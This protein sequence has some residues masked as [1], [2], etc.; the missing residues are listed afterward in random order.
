MP[1]VKGYRNL[2]LMRCRFTSTLFCFV[3]PILLFIEVLSQT[4]WR[5]HPSV[6][7][8]RTREWLS[9]RD[10]T[11]LCQLMPAALHKPFSRVG[12]YNKN[13][14]W[15]Q[16]HIS[17]IVAVNKWRQWLFICIH[18]NISYLCGVAWGNTQLYWCNH[19]HF[20]AYCFFMGN[21]G[22]CG[23]RITIICTKIC[24]FA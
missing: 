15:M 20:A 12:L 5:P 6:S 23:R 13:L 11:V 3:V 7:R 9:I 21:F 18:T 14:C 16:L 19:W 4:S 17:V 10:K 24:N 1:G 2:N 22:L 8:H